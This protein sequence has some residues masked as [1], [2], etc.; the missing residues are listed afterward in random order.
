MKVKRIRIHSVL[1]Y[2]FDFKEDEKMYVA[3]ELTQQHYPLLERYGFTSTDKVHAKVPRPLKSVTILNAEGGW[4]THRDQPKEPRTFERE[5][6]CIDWHGEDHYGVCYQTRDCYPRTRISP[7][8]IELTL[9]N[10]FIRSPLFSC[11]PSEYE[12]IKLAINLFLEIFGE[13]DTMTEQLVPKAPLIHE[14]NLPWTI[15]PVGTL[16]WEKGKLALKEIIDA[17]PRNQQNVIAHRHQTI[18]SYRPECLYKGDEGFWGYIVYAFPQK[19]V[20]VFESN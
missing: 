20:Y 8:C 2:I 18:W 19:N 13:C 10:G 9:Y 12:K 11:R 4:K 1:P 6:H 15:L 16:P 5:Y 7:Q 14:R 3:L 17:V